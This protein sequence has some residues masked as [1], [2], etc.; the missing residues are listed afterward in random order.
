MVNKTQNLENAKN[1]SNTKNTNN[2]IY[3]LEDRFQNYFERVIEICKKCPKNSLT[4][5]IIPQVVASAGSLP[6][7][8]A[9]ATE[10]MSKK[11]FVKSIKISRKETKESRVWIKGLMASVDFVDNEFYLLLQEANEIIYILTSILIKTDK[12]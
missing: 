8:Y 12:K 11:D 10:A 2:K 3:K 5:R 7:N 1:Q 4:I 6:A 9:E